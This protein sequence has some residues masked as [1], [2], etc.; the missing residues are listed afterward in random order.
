MQPTINPSL[1]P[2]ENLLANLK[3]G[4]VPAEFA[5]LIDPQTG[6][7]KL[8]DSWISPGAVRELDP[9]TGARHYQ[10]ALP[11]LLPENANIWTVGPQGATWLGEDGKPAAQ[12]PAAP[13]WLP[14]MDAS[15]MAHMPTRAQMGATPAALGSPMGGAQGVPPTSFRPEKPNTP[16]ASGVMGVPTSPPASFRPGKPARGDGQAESYIAQ[17]IRALMSMGVGQ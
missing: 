4:A 17:I 14:T 2:Y 3:V 5:S 1:L 15:W 12:Q 9:Y 6:S 13:S 10:Y 8:G 11:G 16:P 7:F